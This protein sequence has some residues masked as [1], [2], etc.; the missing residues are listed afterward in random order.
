MSGRRSGAEALEENLRTNTNGAGDPD[1]NERHPGRAYAQ[2]SSTECRANASPSGRSVIDSTCV[3][4]ALIAH[5][6]SGIGL[7]T[8]ATLIP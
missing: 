2:E 6:Q 3:Q 4:S 5:L 8:V 1:Q 7:D